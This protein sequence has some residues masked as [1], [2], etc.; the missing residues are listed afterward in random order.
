MAFVYWIHL[1]HH[2]DIATEG[3]VGIT[4]MDNPP[5]LEPDMS[6]RD[7]KT[8]IV[9][10][11]LHKGSYVGYK[12]INGKRVSKYFSIKKHGEEVAFQLAKDFRDALDDEI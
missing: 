11:T 5:T 3:Y 12:N 4:T 6:A 10:V 1:P 9:G 8:N 2:V 7:T